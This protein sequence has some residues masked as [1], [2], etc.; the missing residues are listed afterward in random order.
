VIELRPLARTPPRQIAAA[1]LLVSCLLIVP[2]WH[3]GY[4]SPASYLTCCLLNTLVLLNAY[5]LFQRFFRSDE[6]YD[7]LVRM[8]VLVFGLIVLCGLVLGSMGRLTSPAYAV[9]LM[10]LLAPFTR[11][12]RPGRLLREQHFIEDGA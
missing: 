6:L 1:A 12:K 4:R 8:A 10:A 3:F 11:F 9:L 2:G 5:V 7:A